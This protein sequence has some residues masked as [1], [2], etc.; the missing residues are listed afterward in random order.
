MKAIVASGGASALADRPSPIAAPG[1]CVV[2]VRAAL[3]TPA[4]IRASRFAKE[5]IVLGQAFVG[6]VE[7][8]TSDDAIGG[9]SDRA[10]DGKQLL[11]KRVVVDPVIRCGRCDRCVGGLSQHCRERTI[12]GLDGRDGGCAVQVAV[13]VRNLTPV[14]DGLDDDRASFAT[15]IASALEATKHVR[16]EGKAYITVLGDDIATLVTAQ[17]MSQLNAAVRIVAHAPATIAVAEKLGV[18]HRLADE[19]GRRGD[20]DVVVDCTGTAESLAF[21]SALV[22]ARGTVVLASLAHSQDLTGRADLAPIVL[23]ELKVQGSFYGPL[24]DAVDLL[25]HRGIEVT[26]LIERRVVID[27]ALPLRQGTLIRCS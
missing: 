22:R 4:D 20:Q 19:V 11:G 3:V 13:P 7:S 15:L 9:V 17:V 18:K 8:V 6:V 26:A 24:H 25:A 12:I 14:P 21:A 27:A 1:D 10:R 16:V 5:P 2:R 23:G